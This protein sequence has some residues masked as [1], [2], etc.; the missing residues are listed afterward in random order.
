MMGIRAASLRDIIRR[1]IKKIVRKY[2]ADMGL[3]LE[4]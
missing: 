3:L 4:E 2:L 1:A